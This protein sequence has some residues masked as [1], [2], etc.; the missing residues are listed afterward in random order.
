MLAQARTIALVA[1]LGGATCAGVTRAAEPDALFRTAAAHYAKQQWQAACDDFAQLLAAA[2]EHE[3]AN[4]AR[5]HY[6]EA[7]VQLGR[8]A[9]A[10]RQFDELVRRDPQ[11]RYAKHA[12]FRSG[13]AA[14][15]AGDRPAALRQLQ[16][17]RQR[18]PDDE[19]NAYVLAHLGRVE[20]DDGKPVAAE[21]LFV[22]ALER[23]PG[24][25][26]ADACRLGLAEA[27]EG[28]HKQ[29]EARR[30]Y[31]AL[32][33]AKSPLT[34]YALLRLAALDNDAGEHAAALE[35][36]ER[37]AREFPGS[38]LVDK[39]ALGRGY[40]LYR[41]GRHADAET[42]LNGLTKHAQL[43]V[44]A[45][46]WLGTSQAAR[47]AWKDAAASFTAGAALDPRHRLCETLSFQAARA[48]L[49]DGQLQ[50]ADEAFDRV[51]RLWP[52][53]ALADQC[54]F[55][56]L[57]ISASR[58]EHAQTVRL[59]D[60]FAAKHPQSSLRADVTAIKGRAL[61]ALG[62]HADAAAALERSL[63]GASNSDMPTK[64][65]GQERPSRGG[66]SRAESQADL[67]MSYARLGRFADA[68]RMVQALYE[69][70]APLAATDETC[71]RV[72]ERAYAGGDLAT[73]ATLF[74]RLVRPD[75]AP[76]MRRRGLM[77]QG[78]CR[79]KSSQWSAAA[80][81]FGRV[82]SEFPDDPAAVEAALLRGRALEHHHDSAA[83][84]AMYRVIIDRHADDSRHA[85]ALDRAARL[86]DK[87]QK[88]SESIALYQRLV[89][90]H[91][92]YPE[93]SAALYRWGWLVRESDPAAAE[94]L[95]ARLRREFPTSA[96][97]PD[98]TLQ[99]A[100]RAF[101]AKKYDEARGLV[102]EITGQQSPAA[103]RQGGWYLEGRI[104]AA[105]GD[106]QGVETSL[107]R[108][109]AEA[110]QSE[111]ALAAAYLRAEAS[112]RRGRYAESA[113]RLATLASQT[114][115]RNQPWSAAAQL[116]RAQALAQLRQWHEALEVA[117]A[118]E[119]EFPDFPEQHEV[120]Y[121]IGRCLA[122]QADFT[123]AREAFARAVQSPRGAATE[124]AV[125]AQWMTGETYFHQ[126]NFAA[127]LAEYEKV[128]KQHRFAQW[129]AAALLQAGKCH[130]HLGQW[131]QA[132]AAYERMLQDFPDHDLAAE[133]AR[134][135]AAARGRLARRSAPD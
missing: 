78:W 68:D 3:R 5:F 53:S 11:H 29:D 91:P 83:A 88:R 102:F 28:L 118:I 125:M 74:G 85:E 39:A 93:V 87:L 124:T 17:F 77:G 106:W 121:V 112:Y 127:A 44:D 94:E 60:A 56:K 16:A 92:D 100:E 15:L 21:P 123:G 33:D 23:Y 67:A 84:L 126:E 99:L 20:L 110:P 49:H 80:E 73:A 89:N 6:G 71:Y 8:Y 75:A 95:F 70:K 61:T 81:S 9:E 4:Q 36:L 19:L 34:D 46:Y 41:L 129:R 82:L 26:L 25:P 97:V 86:C 104:A 35:R 37:L 14:Y 64:T 96:H 90:E 38:T 101:A 45:H 32:I 135:A 109:I 115:R 51:L 120:D 55:G 2:P 62:Q 108:L 111:L 42:V 134:R 22:A 131:D 40:A 114:Q 7:L 54:L 128:D 18:Y 47:T 13:E 113:E 122:A 30:G 52:Q 24:G 69:Q 57:Q 105:T 119:A 132:V 10:R 98:A 48:L 1:A 27:H 58:G 72:A 12:L 130:E 76:E 59:A 31:Q 63:A 103:V 133:A 50:A 66:Q 43:A 79:F 116:R 117:R 107:G 65:A